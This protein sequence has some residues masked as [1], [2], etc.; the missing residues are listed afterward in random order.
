MLDFEQGILGLFGGGDL[1]ASWG[2][3]LGTRLGD[4]TTWLVGVVSNFQDAVG[5]FLLSDLL[6]TGLGCNWL[7]CFSSL[8]ASSAGAFLFWGSL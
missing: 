6:L 7:D 5:L 1:G 4:R 3:F 2:C 8:F